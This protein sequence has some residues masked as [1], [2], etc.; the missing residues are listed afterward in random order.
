MTEE[1]RIETLRR[2]GEVLTEY[3]TL[4]DYFSLTAEQGVDPLDLEAIRE[5]A[6]PETSPQTP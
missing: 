1:T 4:L 6:T 5:S 2:Y 3:P